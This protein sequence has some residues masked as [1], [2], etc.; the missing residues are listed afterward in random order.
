[1]KFELRVLTVGE[2]LRF[3]HLQRWW[4]CLTRANRLALFN[5]SL[6][7]TDSLLSVEVAFK[8]V[9]AI[10]L[11]L[12]NFVGV[13]CTLREACTYE[14]A[15]VAGSV[16]QPQTSNDNAGQGGQQHKKLVLY[17]DRV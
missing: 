6:A 2:Y 10:L 7:G 15:A 14:N 5:T 8:A 13:T 11:G 17:V 16:G 3:K 9:G 1:M 4:L 12:T